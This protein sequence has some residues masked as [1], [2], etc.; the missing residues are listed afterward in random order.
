MNHKIGVG[1]RVYECIKWHPNVDY[2]VRE[3]LGE[4]IVTL[5]VKSNKT[6]ER[7]MRVIWEEGEIAWHPERELVNINNV[8]KAGD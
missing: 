5:I 7:K 1:D 8:F 2:S 6:A 4:G 3:K